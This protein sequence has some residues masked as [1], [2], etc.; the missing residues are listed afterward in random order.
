MVSDTR[1][2]GLLG[3][4]IDSRSPRVTYRSSRMGRSSRLFYLFA[5]PWLAGFL[6]LTLIPL[7]Y[8]FAL[9][10]M[11]YDGL[12]GRSQWVGL[13]NYREALGS[14]DLR[15]ALLR[16]AV[17]VVTAV[18]LLT[19]A[20]LS[21]A[22]FLNPP[23]RGRTLLRAVFFLP[24]ILPPVASALMFKLLFDR[25]TGLINAVLERLGLGSVFWLSD[26]QARLV[27]ML[28][29]LWALGGGM[30]I[31]LAALQDIPHEILDACSVDGAG[32]LRRLWSVTLPLVSPA[33][34][35][36]VVINTIFA[37]QIL[38]EPALL[39]PTFAADP[40]NAFAATQTT[41]RFVLVEVATQ[42]LTYAR[43]GYAAAVLWILFSLLLII[44]VVLLRISRRFVFYGGTQL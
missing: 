35:Y 29:F 18:P 17:F 3:S 7:L 1:N 39:A 42:L 23:R 22:L 32:R 38:V 6:L 34:F 16:T 21:L 43:F 14:P 40:S 15:A 8:S 36:Q 5:S 11:S 41:N 30:L 10:F 33:I 9:S 2:R 28:M 44:T 25:D 26:P 24:A 20:S 19:A 4:V 31:F 13:T 27:L 12:T 37:A